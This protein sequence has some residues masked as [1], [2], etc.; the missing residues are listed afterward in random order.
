MRKDVSMFSAPQIFNRNHL[1]TPVLNRCYDILHSLGQLSNLVALKFR[2]P[3]SNYSVS[4]NLMKKIGWWDTCADAIGEDFHTC[5]KCYWKILETFYTIP[6]YVPFNQLS[7][8]TGRGCV[9]DMIARFWQ[10]ERHC[11]GA[12]DVAYCFHMLFNTRFRFRNL[13]LTFLVL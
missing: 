4:Y 13:I 10:A 9:K 3:L 2:F 12:S 5:Q 8:T 7:L 6:I 1:K 11:L